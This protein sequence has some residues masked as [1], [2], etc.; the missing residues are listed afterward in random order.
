[1]ITLVLLYFMLLTHYKEPVHTSHL[2]L[3]LLLP[4]LVRRHLMQ[5]A[6]SHSVALKPSC[7]E[8]KSKETSSISLYCHL[9][10]ESFTYKASDPIVLNNPEPQRQPRHIFT[11]NSAEVSH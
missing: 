9:P 11:Q 5:T 7:A 1:M 2:F 8:N 3:S 4:V 6:N 10:P